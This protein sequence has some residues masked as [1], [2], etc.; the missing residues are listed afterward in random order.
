MA[1]RAWIATAVAAVTGGGRSP[2]ALPPSG[3]RRPGAR[4]GG[5]HQRPGH[6]CTPCRSGLGTA[7]GP[8]HENVAGSRGE[9]AR[10]ALAVPSQASASTLTAT[11]CCARPSRSRRAPVLARIWS[12]PTWSRAVIGGQRL[13]RKVALRPG[14]LG[15]S[16]RSRHQRSRPARICLHTASMAVARLRHAPGVPRGPCDQRCSRHVVAGRS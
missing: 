10:R 15:M 14:M 6:I 13:G 4:P 9:Y 11:A 12:A 5:L 2:L 1:R 16:L 8:R 3:H 7:G